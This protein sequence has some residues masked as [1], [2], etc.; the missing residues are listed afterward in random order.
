MVQHYLVKLLLAPFSLLYGVGVSVRD[1]LYRNGVLKGVE[2]N[3]PVISVGNLSVGGAGKTP[4]I[5]YLIRLLKEYLEVATLSRGY[6]RKTKGFLT[7]QAGMTAEQVGDEPLQFKRKFP[8]IHVTVAESRTFG[9]PQIMMDR[10]STQ[11]VLL[12]DAFQHRSIKPGLNILLTEF[13]QPFTRDYLLPS[14]RLR[15]WRSAYRR[16]DIIVVSKCPLRV[17]EAE[18]QAL[19]GEINPLPHQQL[20][21]SYY[22]YLQPYFILDSRYQLH[23]REDMDVLLICAIAGTDYLVR[24]L[25]ERVNTVTVLE[26]EDHHYFTKHDVAHLQ[27]TY[28]RLESDKKVV[29][30]TEKDAMRLELHKTFLQ[31]QRL[32][33]FALPVQVRFHF[34]QGPAFDEQIKSFLLNFRI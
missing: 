13:D 8:D 11:V 31:E 16:A 7:V 18:R 19:I 28:E 6:S 2:F 12:D 15:E 30:T 20:F 34:G 33:V 1:M 17:T 9:I 25:E 24:Y 5:E 22:D 4:H 14:G 21:F 32:P 10:P 29:I 3:V 26:Y 23:L 27:S